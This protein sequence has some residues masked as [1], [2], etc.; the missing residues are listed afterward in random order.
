MSKERW[1]MTKLK[2]A[3]EGRSFKICTANR[4]EYMAGGHF[5]H[6]KEL[7]RFLQNKGICTFFLF[8]FLE[9][10]GFLQTGYQ[11]FLGER[12][13]PLYVWLYI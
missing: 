1:Y 7:M 6:L 12:N 13:S 2:T 5:T 10:Q 9:N 8:I 4:K 3:D 11:I